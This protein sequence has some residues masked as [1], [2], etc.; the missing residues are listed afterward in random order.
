MAGLW[1]ACGLGLGSWIFNFF[2]RNTPQAKCD[3]HRIDVNAINNEKVTVLRNLL[4]LSAAGRLA[5]DAVH[6]HYCGK[7]RNKPMPLT[8]C[9]AKDGVAAL[10]DSAAHLAHCGL[11]GQT[12]SRHNALEVSLLEMLKAAKYGWGWRREVTLFS[13]GEGD[14]VS[15]RWRSD[16][17]G[18]RPEDGKM[19]VIDVNVITLAA[20]SYRGARRT[21][22]SRCLRTLD[23]AYWQQRLSCALTGTS[24]SRVLRMIATD[25]MQAAR[26]ATGGKDAHVVPR[27]YGRVGYDVPVAQSAT[28]RLKPYDTASDDDDASVVDEANAYAEGSVFRS[29]AGAGSAVD[30]PGGGIDDPGGGDTDD[31]GSLDNL[32]TSTTTSSKTS[33]SF[34][35][36][37][38]TT[39]FSLMSLSDKSAVDATR[40]GGRR[41]YMDDCATGS[42]CSSCAIPPRVAGGLWSDGVGCDACCYPFGVL[43]RGCG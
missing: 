43:C 41:W 1:L 23:E 22:R 12:H 19:C 18:F 27:V 37:S 11:D 29:Q 36:S 10:A 13:E 6:V 42:F 5:A 30:D 34:V 26:I 3:V 21:L 35:S 7:D 31:L 9:P 20:A 38:L 15:K 28:F 16:I 32:A 8:N 25:R 4:G 17:V 14:N 39:G 2:T 40:L 33:V 24:A